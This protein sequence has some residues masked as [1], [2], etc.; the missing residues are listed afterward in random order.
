[1]SKEVK[2]FIESAERELKHRLELEKTIK[3]LQD[4]IISLGGQ[5]PEQKSLIIENDIS[6]K[7]MSV[8]AEDFKILKDMVTSQRDE[9]GKKESN[10]KALESKIDE[11]KSE[12][13]KSRKII[14]ELKEN[15][16][17]ENALNL[18]D[19]LKEEKSNFENEIAGLNKKIAD[20]EEE[21]EIL[22]QNI[23]TAKDTSV[24]ENDLDSVE[25]L[26]EEKS[27]FENEIAGLN[28]K[29]ADLEEENE[30]LQQVIDSVEI[31]QEVIDNMNLK[32]I[33]YVD[34]ISSLEEINETQSE[35]IEKIKSERDAIAADLQDKIDELIET[36]SDLEEKN[37][38]LR[39]IEQTP[40]I[41]QSTI[42][43]YEN[44]IIDLEK[45]VAELENE[46][47][48]LD[49]KNQMLKAALLLHVDVESKHVAPESNVMEDEKIISIP[50]GI[51]EERVKERDQVID[52]I[53]ESGQIPQQEVSEKSEE[54]EISEWIEEPTIEP[55]TLPLSY[56]EA[57]EISEEPEKSEETEISEWIEEP[58]IEPE[59]S[60]PPKYEPSEISEPSE[61]LE[62]V[63]PEKLSET[64]EPTSTQEQE[65][66]IIESST[67][68]RLCPKC[69]NTNKLLIREM[70]DKT[71]IISAVA[72]L[73]G[74]KY[75]CGMCGAEWR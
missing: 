13:E 17:F 15:S 2:D 41:D 53:E 58:T 73:Y 18:I 64:S 47:K 25:A 46:N 50:K 20:L 23:D 22:L 57:S 66:V 42:T 39:E 40:A 62:P 8:D 34:Q 5:I 16:N 44:N 72:G 19:A 37:K 28:K 48:N 31:N 14:D 33:E 24:V 63:E 59:I 61:H 1:M 3:Q 45:K 36:I 67:G 68:R 35:N 21:N 71:K 51:V 43:N 27:K 38:A 74:K 4:Q 54:T 7:S 56:D 12:L 29:I 75:K 60:P 32:I 30:K 6:P 9:I 11:L 65:E 26:K 52:S 70:P 10:I 69:G 49:E 55:E